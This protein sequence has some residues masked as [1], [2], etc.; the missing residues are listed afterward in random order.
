VPADAAVDIADVAVLDGPV[1]TDT[2]AVEAADAGAFI[3]DRHRRIALELVG[4]EQTED[5]GGRWRW[6]LATDSGMSRGAWQ[7]PAR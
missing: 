1:G 4:A 5:L 3:D 6:P 2:F 7:A